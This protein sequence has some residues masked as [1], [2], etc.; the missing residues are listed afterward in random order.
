MEFL[1]E[2]LKK[3]RKKNNEY[4]I[5]VEIDNK[6]DSTHDIKEYSG[7]TKQD[8]LNKVNDVTKFIN[9]T[10]VKS[11][12]KHITMSLYENSCLVSRQKLLRIIIK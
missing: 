12:Y 1:K 10:V 3:C 7:T 4:L 2:A 8:I 6:E 5:K 11:S 9:S